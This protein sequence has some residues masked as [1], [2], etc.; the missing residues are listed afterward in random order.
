MI[1][2][3]QVMSKGLPA[4]TTCRTGAV[5]GFPLGFEPT[6]CW[7]HAEA[8]PVYAAAARVTIET[9]IAVNLRRKM[10]RLW[11]FNKNTVILLP[12]MRKRERE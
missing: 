9:R 5:M 11:I 7:E 10:Q 2:T 6:G 3:L 4:G 12:V 8:R 1:R